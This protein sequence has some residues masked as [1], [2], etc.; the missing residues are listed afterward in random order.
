VLLLVVLFQPFRPGTTGKN[1]R[2]FLQKEPLHKVEISRNFL[3]TLS[4]MMP[5]GSCMGPFGSVVELWI[6][7]PTVN[8]SIPL[9]VM[10]FFFCPPPPAYASFCVAPFVDLLVD[11][12]AIH[13]VLFL[14]VLALSFSV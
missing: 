7:N 9:T 10:T 8:G 2:T 11:I 13:P 12:F 5:L 14:L 3:K 4:C 6:P 1:G